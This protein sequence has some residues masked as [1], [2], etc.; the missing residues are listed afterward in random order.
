MDGQMSSVRKKVRLERR[1]ARD[2]FLSILISFY[3]L[4]QTDS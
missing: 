3:D 2:L 1:L 4:C